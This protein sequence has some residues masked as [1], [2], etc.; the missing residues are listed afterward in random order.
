MNWTTVIDHLPALP[1]AVLLVGACVLMIADVH[2]KDERRALSYW[3]AQGT[4]ALCLGSTLF[5]L[6]GTGMQL[7][8]EQPVTTSTTSSTDLFVADFMSPVEAGDI[9]R[10]CSG[11][12]YRASVV[13]R[14]R[15]G[16]RGEFIQ[17]LL[18]FSLLGM[19]ILASAQQLP[20]RSSGSS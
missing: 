17:C 15:P 11:L 12:V 14:P 16:L 19:M 20:H 6:Y 5:V 7:V 8:H 2:S 9:R 13:I 10:R 18:L 4:L 3:I 1:E